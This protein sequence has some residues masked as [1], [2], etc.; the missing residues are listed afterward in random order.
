MTNRAQS[1]NIGF[2][3]L[4]AL[5]I[6][7]A[8]VIVAV[9]SSALEDV[10]EQT[11]LSRAEHSMTLLDARV[12]TVGLGENSVQTVRLGRADSGDYTVESETGW[13]RIEHQNYTANER[14]T[15][16]NASL[17]SI[18]YQTAGTEVT[19]QGGGVWRHQDGGTSM[20]SPPEFHYRGTTLTLP[21]L[22]IRSNDAAT[23]DAT[24]RIQRE[25]EIVR[26][27]PNEAES[28][29]V[30]GEPYVNPIR[31]GTASVTV[32]SR[33][34]KG[35]ADYFRT[36]TSG[37]VSVDDGNRTA[38]VVLE[39]ADIAGPFEFPEK[40]GEVPVRRVQSGH[41]ITDFETSIKKD[42]GTFNNLY[43][44]FYI[45]EGDKAY[46]AAV[47]VP[48]GIG[49][50][51][52]QDGDPGSEELTM[53]VY[54]YD[55]G[56]PEG[57]H[58]WSNDSI[59]SDSGDVQLDCT[60]DD[61]TVIRIDFT[62]TEQNLTY[63]GSNVG[64]ETAID[65]DDR[66][67][68]ATA[69]PDPTTFAHT[70]DDGENTTYTYGDKQNIRILTRHYFATF[71]PDFEIRVFHGPGDRGTTQIDTSGSGGTLRYERASGGAYITYLHV[72][73]NNVSVELN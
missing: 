51:Y 12:A 3:L 39:T 27:F 67:D 22:R 16:Y 38:T 21:V 37:N 28:Y 26:V 29:D 73:E 54:Y 31:D 7:G 63:G 43:V 41:S 11:S 34:Y 57:V 6:T 61:D 70:D 4:L 44:S 14:E 60:E 71:G 65:W 45:E 66:N 40:G 58:R 5:T 2:I 23:G 24:A 50:N 35:W 47:E 49:N 13:L 55:D 10:Q 53:D 33:Y 59:P 64:E 69:K 1:S 30:T 62:G 19:Y 25:G 36:R 18:T 15:I 42:S 72:T 32:H 17:G 52:C 48:N 68:S 46:E 56:T 8:G 20:V 9:G